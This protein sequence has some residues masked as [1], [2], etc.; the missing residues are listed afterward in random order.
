MTNW[1]DVTSLSFNALLLLE[2]VQ[3][4]WFPAWR[5][6]SEASLAQALR[7]HPAVA[8]YLRHNVEVPA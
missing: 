3:L 1:L 6:T 4:R 7:A 2:R 8:W 5:W